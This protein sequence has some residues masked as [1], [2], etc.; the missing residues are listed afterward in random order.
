MSELDDSFAIARDLLARLQERH[1]AGELDPAETRKT[2]VRVVGALMQHGRPERTSDKGPRGLGYGQSGK[3]E[4]GRDGKPIERHDGIVPA[5][6]AGI[7]LGR[8]DAIDQDG[9]EAFRPHVC[10]ATIGQVAK[11]RVGFSAPGHGP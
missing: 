1:S 2:L 3:Q 9:F 7:P 11:S 8:A 10:G 6:G 4:V 5:A